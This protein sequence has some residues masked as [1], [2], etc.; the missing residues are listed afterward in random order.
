[1][2]TIPH[3][4]SLITAHLDPDADAISSAVTVAEYLKSVGVSSVFIRFHGHIASHMQWMLTGQSIVDS[5]PEGVEQIIVLDS[6]PEK[7]RLGWA[8][9]PNKKIINIDHHKTRLSLHNPKKRVYVVDRCSTA[10]A[11]ILDFNIRNPIL[12]AGLYGDTHFTI[13]LNEVKTCLARLKFTDEQ[14]EQY[15]SG[16][17]PVRDRRTLDALR[18]AKSRFCRNGFLIVEL[19]STEDS[20]VTQEIMKTL[21]SYSESVCLIQTDNKVLLRT[22]NSNL[23]VSTIAKVYGGGGHSYASG[24]TLGEGKRSAFKSLIV[25]LDIEPVTI[26]IVESD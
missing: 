24:L 20:D 23:D 22:R 18:T 11:L 21:N 6:G 4:P 5:V 12:L 10:A 9:P 16:L 1:M 19:A 13:R 8:L 26:E 15:L 3:K 25:S 7:E 14:A 17:K 2:Y